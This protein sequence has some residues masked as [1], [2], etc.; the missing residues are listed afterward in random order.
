VTT[1]LSL[2]LDEK[3]GSRQQASRRRQKPTAVQVD[4]E[5]TDIDR[6]LASFE[7]THGGLMHDRQLDIEHII[8]TIL[9]ARPNLPD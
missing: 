7:A 9:A 3:R 8:E 4:N 5:L 2:P 6:I 1:G